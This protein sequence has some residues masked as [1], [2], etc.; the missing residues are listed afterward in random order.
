M[1]VL[2][3]LTEKYSEISPVPG[4][5]GTKIGKTAAPPEYPPE[6]VFRTWQGQYL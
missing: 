2:M 5:E 1:V 6:T 3:L 4:A